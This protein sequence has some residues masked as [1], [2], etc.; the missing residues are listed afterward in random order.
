VPA[1]NIFKVYKSKC[2]GKGDIQFGKRFARLIS[3]AFPNI[4]RGTRTFNG[5]RTNSYYL[6]YK[7]DSMEGTPKNK[8]NSK[9][10]KIIGN[11]GQILNK[12]NRLNVQS[13][14]TS[15]TEAIPGASVRIHQVSAND[16][17]FKK[18]LTF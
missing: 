5:R 16:D 14:V 15:S 12:A 10:K 17:R 7:Y 8:P 2:T 9:R 3:M 18:Y 4:K 13:T 11:R 6:K 1:Q